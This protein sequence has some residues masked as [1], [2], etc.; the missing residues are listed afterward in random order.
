MSSCS[1]VVRYSLPT[2]LRD[3]G[4]IGPD[5]DNAILYLVLRVWSGDVG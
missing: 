5:G 3:D 4:L 2:H 1:L